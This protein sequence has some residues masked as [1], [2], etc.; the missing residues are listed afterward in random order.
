MNLTVLIPTFNREKGLKNLL[1]NLY[2]QGHIGEYKIVISDNHSDY[3]VRKMIDDN[4]DKSFSEIITV[5]KWNFNV[6]MSSNISISYLLVDTRWCWCISDDDK[7]LDGSIDTVLSDIKKFDNENITA[8]KYSLLNKV[9]HENRYINSFDDFLNYYSVK[10]RRGELYYL[11]ML[12]NMDNIRPYLGLLTEHSYTYISF[13]IPLLKGLLDGKRFFVSSRPC[14]EYSERADDNWSAKR[15]VNVML[16]V[17]TF[18]DIDF[19]ISAKWQR[20]LLKVISQNLPLIRITG[21]ITQQKTF[22]RRRLLWKNSY[23]MYKRNANVF[24]R[25]LC[26]ILFV[27]NFDLYGLCRKI[28]YRHINKKAGVRI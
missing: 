8:V 12:Y 1:E 24:M 26:Y 9:Q 17:R 13:L 20:K 27:T 18:A 14:I 28:Y 16:G 5:N 3:D 23:F 10:S 6:G 22:F 7:V 15:Y 11:S 2:S 25:L 19:N 21:K 4:F